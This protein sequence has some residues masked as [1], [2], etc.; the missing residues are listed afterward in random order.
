MVN[1]F[2]GE[3]NV[4]AASCGHGS[5]NDRKL[6]L[7]D[8]V[9]DSLEYGVFST[10]LVLMNAAAKPKK[11]G[12]T[13]LAVSF[14]GA[15]KPGMVNEIAYCVA[16]AKCNIIEC[17]VTALGS[18]VGAHLLISGRWNQIAKAE[19]G[20]P[21]LAHSFGVELIVQRTEL[22]RLDETLLPYAIYVVALDEPG[23][24]HKI[25]DFFDQQAINIIELNTHT[26]QAR[27][28][29][30]QMMSLN[31]QISIPA[32]IHIADLRDRFMMFCDDLN[33]DAIMEPEKY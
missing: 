18:G 4:L 29:G 22:V 7:Y 3:T 31:M 21:K 8:L 14:L 23:T 20:L 11:I 24:I 13:Y 6:R 25:T 2:I 5:K 26:Y 33:L 19:T 27:Y 15:N 28:T 16:K 1:H 32:D 9:T 30:S 12:L 10:G 17:R